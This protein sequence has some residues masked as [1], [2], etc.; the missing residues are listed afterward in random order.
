V[1]RGAVRRK[2]AARLKDFVVVR[3]DGA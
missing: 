2:A 1:L 3:P